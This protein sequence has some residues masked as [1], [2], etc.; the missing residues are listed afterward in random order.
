MLVYDTLP[1]QRCQ[2]CGDDSLA[3]IMSVPEPISVVC[4]R[5][6]AVSLRRKRQGRCA[7]MPRR[8]QGRSKS[9]HESMMR[10]K[11]K[12]FYYKLHSIPAAVYLCSSMDVVEISIR[13]LLDWFG[14]RWRCLMCRGETEDVVPAPTP[15][16]VESHWESAVTILSQ[17]MFYKYQNGQRNVIYKTSS[18]LCTQ[19]YL[20]ALPRLPHRTTLQHLE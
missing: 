1:R 6:T 18:C 5:V 11:R 20:P 17:S 13:R 12:R 8:A 9:D 3:H 16:L 4:L 10:R 15:V 7:I 19:N 2:G 14:Q